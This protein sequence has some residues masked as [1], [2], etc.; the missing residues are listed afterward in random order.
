MISMWSNFPKNGKV[1]FVKYF[2]YKLRISKFRQIIFTK[3]EILAFHNM[4]KNKNFQFFKKVKFKIRP[5]RLNCRGQSYSKTKLR[6]LTKFDFYHFFILSKPKIFK[7]LGLAEQ[8]SI[9][10]PILRSAKLQQEKK[11]NL[12]WSNITILRI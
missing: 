7:I 11:N 2:L 5:F 4:G 12:K 6:I 9:I 3:M 1:K 10:S 8:K